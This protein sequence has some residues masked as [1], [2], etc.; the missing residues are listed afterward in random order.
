MKLLTFLEGGA[1]RTGILTA[2]PGTP[3]AVVVD[4][5]G[6]VELL[7]RQARRIYWRTPWRGPW[8]TLTAPRDCW[9]SCGTGARP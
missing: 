5:G 1:Y 7:Q 6:A 2:R 4:V 3:D 8:G 9:T